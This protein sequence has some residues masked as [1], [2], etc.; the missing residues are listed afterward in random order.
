MNEIVIKKY[1][2]GLTVLLN[3]DIPFETLYTALGRKFRESAG[4]F[5]NAR[6][7]VSFKGRE[8]DPEEERLLVDAISDNSELTVLNIL[9]DDDDDVNQFYIKAGSR[10][11]GAGDGNMLS[12]F[13]KGT[14][15]AGE[16]IESDTDL[17]ILG[18]IN[19]GG[20]VISAGNITVLGTVYGTAKAGSKGDRNKFVIALELRPV[21]I[22]IADES[23]TQFVRRG[24]F[25]A[26]S[27][28]KIV[29]I[30]DGELTADEM[31]P[32]T[33]EELKLGFAGKSDV[34]ED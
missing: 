23:A 28:P 11:P 7:A 26:K 30:K 34:K 21:R 5:G 18:D 1:P 17:I 4:F 27:T 9:G 19:P 22:S 3:P 24:I 25:R 2:E 29:Y 32:E 20:E 15:K 6:L 14:V 33:V 16:H 8:L 12:S 10:F 13:Y 31:N